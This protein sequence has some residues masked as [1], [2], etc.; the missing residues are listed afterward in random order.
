MFTTELLKLMIFIYRDFI[1]KNIVQFEILHD[2]LYLRAYNVM[3]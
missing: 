2:I 3:K 1:Q